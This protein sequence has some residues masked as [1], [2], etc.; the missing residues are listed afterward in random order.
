[1]KLRTKVA[2]GGAAIAAMAAMAAIFSTTGFFNEEAGW[3]KSPSPDIAEQ[4]GMREERI[5]SLE[6]G[7]TE[8][9]E[10]LTFR[11]ALQNDPEMLKIYAAQP[12]KYTP[13]KRDYFLRYL[14]AKFAGEP[15]MPCILAIVKEE[16][17]RPPGCPA[18]PAGPRA[19]PAVTPSP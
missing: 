11:L 2:V 3:T 4:Q 17:A 14:N 12:V 6:R 13:G 9:A 15:G 1:M 19:E 7:E 18:A 16:P 5:R 8:F 10:Y